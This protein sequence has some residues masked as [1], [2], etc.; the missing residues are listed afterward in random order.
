MPILLK[1]FKT[2]A[3]LVS[4][5]LAIVFLVVLVSVLTHIINSYEAAPKQIVSMSDVAQYKTTFEKKYDSK[6]LGEV[7]FIPMGYLIETFLFKDQNTIILSGFVWQKY[8]KKAITPESDFSLDFP[9]A[10]SKVYIE[11]AYD[12]E[13]GDYRLIGWHFTGL[14]LYQAFDYSLYPLDQQEIWIYSGSMDL[15]KNIIY[16]PDLVSYKSTKP[17]DLFGLHNFINVFEY[18]LKESYFQYSFDK[19]DT[20]FGFKN[21]GARNNPY[22]F[23]KIVIQR[24]FIDSMIL[25]LLPITVAW[26]ILF[27]LTM[28]MFPDPDKS[29]ILGS[30]TMG[31]LSSLGGLF[32]A[33]VVANLNLRSKFIGQPPTYMEY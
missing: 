11:K 28:V 19:V 13:E 9:E 17:Y 23:Y 3:W 7:I 12:V 21:F 16:T 27:G 15:T 29:K 20:S 4:Y 31:M 2:K 1:D 10:I 30:S 14:T 8:P 6:T 25:Y 18:D 24:H 26:S 32:F 33:V 22:L 5:S